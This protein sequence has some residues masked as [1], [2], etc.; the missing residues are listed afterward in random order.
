MKNLKNR[1]LNLFAGAALSTTVAG[2]P[3]A[4]IQHLALDALSVKRIPVALDRLTTVRFPSAVS[5]LQSVFVSTQPHPQALFLLLFQPGSAF[6]SLRALAPNARTT[7]NVVWKDQ[8]YVLELIESKDPWLS[9]TFEAMTSAVRSP[10]S[11]PRTRSPDHLLGLLDTAKAY[12]LLRQQHPAAVAGVEVVRPNTFHDYGDY[13]IR[14]EEIFRFDSDDT[15]VFRIVAH[16]QT[17]S[18]ISFLPQS[19]MVRAG[20]K[21]F[22]QSITD[23]TGILPA[24]TDLPIYFAITGSP[25]GSRN[26]LSPKNEFMVLLSRL[27]AP[28]S[29]SPKAKYQSSASSLEQFRLVTRRKDSPA[30]SSASSPANDDSIASRTDLL[31]PRSRSHNLV[32][33]SKPVDSQISVPAESQRSP[34]IPVSTATSALSGTSA[35]PNP[36]LAI[37]HD[38]VTE[39]SISQATTINI[40]VTVT[41]RSTPPEATTSPDAMLTARFSPPSRPLILTPIPASYMASVPV[42]QRNPA[43]ASYAHRYRALAPFP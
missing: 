12:S 22:Y 16:N 19:L 28:G 9:V 32:T 11:Q 36:A 17:T 38:H 13:T 34:N 42:Y 25:D 29:V 15:L 2:Q 33:R 14:T 20:Q 26:A 8:T 10:S 7:L 27:D 41:V 18:P 43:Y 5:D 23:A 40:T 37:L 6:F 30:T 31:I 35:Q 1:V 24:Q 4:A 39:P 3:T 21:V